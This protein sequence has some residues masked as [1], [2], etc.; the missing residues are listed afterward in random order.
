MLY[1]RAGAVRTRFEVPYATSGTAVRSI[2][3]RD[4]LRFGGG[5]EIGLGGRARLRA[6]YTL[7]EYDRYEVSYGTRADAF[8]HSEALFRLGVSWGV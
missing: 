7:T 5:L 6:D 2:M 1:G 8:D 4:G 3:S